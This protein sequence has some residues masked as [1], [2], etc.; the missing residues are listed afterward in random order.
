M[1]GRTV[2]AERINRPGVLLR[3][4]RTYPEVDLSQGL[5]NPRLEWGL[6]M[7]WTA[8]RL[9]RAEG[10]PGRPGDDLQAWA[11]TVADIETTGPGEVPT[12]N[13]TV[14]PVDTAQWQDEPGLVSR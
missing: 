8:L 12:P 6:F 10:D 11:D 14:P 9:D 1:D 7:A 5:L 3:L 13:P 2:R 4:E